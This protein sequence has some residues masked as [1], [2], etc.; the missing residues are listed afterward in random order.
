MS[1]KFLSPGWRMPRNA[2]QSKSS[3]YSIDFSGSG[4]KITLN[5]SINLGT[6]SS[7]S[8]WIKPSNY[9]V[10]VLGQTGFT[11][12]YVIYLGSNG[13]LF[14]NLGWNGGSFGGKIIGLFDGQTSNQSQPF[15]SFM[16]LNSWNHLVITRNGD[17]VTAYINGYKRD[18]GNFAS[19]SLSD[20][21]VF[22]HIGVQPPSNSYFNGEM[23]SLSAFNYVLSDGS[24]SVD[25]LATGDI[26]TLY[27]SSS[28]GIGNPMSLSPKPVAYYPLGTSAYN[29]EYLA[30]NNA[31]GDYVFDFS[32]DLVDSNFSLT[33]GQTQFSASIWVKF[34]GSLGSNESLIANESGYA[35]DGFAIFKDT[36]NKIVFKCEGQT[37]VGTTTVALNKW[38]LAT[39][40]YNAGAMILYVNGQQEATQTTST[41]ITEPSTPQTRLGKYITAGAIPFTG[42]LSNAQIWNSK[43][44]A[45]EVETLYNY[46]SPIQT[47]ANIPQSSNLKAWYKLDASEVYNSTTT[48][49][50]IDNN[51]NPSAYPSSLNFDGTNDYMTVS[52]STAYSSYSVSCWV[53]ADTLSSYARLVSLDSVNHR[54]LGLHDD[55]TLISGYKVGGSWNQLF[56]S[57]T[58]TIGTWNHIVLVDN[59]TNTKIYV[60]GVENT[61]SNS[62]AVDGPTY[63]IG[64]YNGSGNFLDGKLSNISTWNAA[65]TLAQVTE[66]YNNGTPSNLSSHSATS[67]LVSWWKLNNTTTGIEDSKGSNNGTNNGATEYAGFVNKLAGDSSGMSQANLVQSD[68]QTVAPYSKYAM[69]FDGIND[70]I[71]IPSFMSNLPS[72]NIYTISTWVKTDSDTNCLWGSS[73]IPNLLYAFVTNGTTFGVQRGSAG[74]INIPN[75]LTVGEWANVVA[76]F[77][78]TTNCKL[79]INNV[80]I[81]DVT[82][83]SLGT[84]TDDF[85]ISGGLNGYY[86]A[87]SQSNFSVWNSAL[88]S[89][90]VSEIYNEGLPGNLNS[91][92]AYSNLVSW[93]Q[94]GENS[95]F[96]GNDWI[97]A[98]E[99]GTNNGTS[100]GMP[101]GALTNGVGTT[102]NGVSTGMSEGNLVGNAPYSTANAI[103]SNMAVTARVTGSGNTP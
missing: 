80:F 5:S 54:F 45:T 87:C 83:G 15:T 49:W 65:L 27:G 76:V 55:G 4:D 63:Y 97:C 98:D 52:N 61:L 1:T 36:N 82:V 79:Y 28:T 94:L 103:S 56:T 44:E 66:I 86:L 25:T 77:D 48:E 6:T 67:N 47:L 53:N 43:L 40:T 85:K 96:D 58:I 18:F 84:V 37:A 9:N 81:Q 59:G 93:W 51:Q 16:T 69:N 46:G 75:L 33:T 89:S 90:Q 38:Y 39:V 23:D 2:N 7:I 35:A 62:I 72:N 73:S 22:D 34:T 60:N 70:Y 95:S 26:A 50:N 10:A 92:S 99:K 100:A 42:E 91:H 88:T 71:N 57:S 101:V 31:I 17:T 3:N 41:S 24:V 29:G 13:R 11:Y 21:T 64:T 102:A 12:A 78:S 19:S 14:F 20:D 74:N 8:I 30:E 68:L 32:S